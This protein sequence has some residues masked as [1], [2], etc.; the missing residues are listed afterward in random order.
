[1]DNNIIVIASKRGYFI[2]EEGVLYNPKGNVIGY[3]SSGYVKTDIRVEGNRKSFSAHRLQA[4]QKYGDKLFKDGIVVRHIDGNPSNNS[5]DNILIGTHSDNM[6][7][8]PTNIRI[9]KSLHAT[10]FVRK[11]DKEEIK[12]FHEK[13]RSY[14]K[15]MEIFNISSKGTLNYILNN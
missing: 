15:T 1:M 2:T 7:D 12:K 14:K 11:Y 6:M 3:L 10:S 9:K 4:Y 8:I 5:W 13:Q